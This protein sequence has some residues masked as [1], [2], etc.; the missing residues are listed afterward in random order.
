MT[1]KHTKLRGPTKAETAKLPPFQGITPEQIVVPKTQAECQNAVD[2]IVSA[3]V[4]GFDTEARPTFQAGQKSNGPHV[5]QFALTDKAFIFQLHRSEC[6]KAAADLISSNTLLKVGFGLR[7][8]HKQIR[9]RLAIALNHVVDLDQV[10]RKLGYGGQ[11]GI[12]GAVGVLFKQRFKKSKSTTTS[13]WARPELTPRQIL[14]A[15]NDAY[16]ALK[17]REALEKEGHL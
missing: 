15:A 17:I 5:V 13:N 16:A 11:I 1:K 14:Y 2:E 4:T 12:R 6:Q 7:N 3:G 8:D 10:F 9:H